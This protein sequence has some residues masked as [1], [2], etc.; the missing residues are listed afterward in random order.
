MT[1]EQI[2]TK[3]V[4]KELWHICVESLHC[5]LLPTLKYDHEGEDSAINVN[6]TAHHYNT[7]Q[8]SALEA[9]GDILKVIGETLVLVT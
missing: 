1:C 4:I 7:K 8:C 2:V 9:L 3:L 6:F 5:M